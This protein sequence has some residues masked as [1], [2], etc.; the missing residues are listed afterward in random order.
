M[1]SQDHCAGGPETAPDVPT[2]GTPRRPLSP[3]RGALRPLAFRP[4]QSDRET[5]NRRATAPANARN[6]RRA[7]DAVLEREAE[8]VA[9]YAE[10]EFAGLVTVTAADEDALALACASYE[11][12]AAQAGLD[13][14]A[15]DGRHDLGLVCAL[16][17]GR[18]L[19]TR[20][21]V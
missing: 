12:A 17:L 3:S 9:G 21:L 19:A 13:L 16:P 20:S 1:S 18:G 14:R 4:K 8:I 2:A 10:L 11:Q 7:Q 5:R 6:H 15:L